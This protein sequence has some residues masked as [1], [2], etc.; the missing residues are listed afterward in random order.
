MTTSPVMS[1]LRDG[2]PITLI[3]DLVSLSDPASVA[4]NSVERPA[5][6]P[7]WLEA[8]ITL[9]SRDVAATA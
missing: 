1:W 7:I 3:C 2:V 5:S 6:D 8:A 4:I 9:I